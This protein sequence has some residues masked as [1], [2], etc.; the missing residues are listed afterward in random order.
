MNGESENPPRDD[1]DVPPEGLKDDLLHGA[2]E[3]AEFMFGDA[4][5]RRRIFH[6]VA[7]TKIPV[8]RL[9]AMICA[10]RSVLVRWIA[11]QE[12]RVPPTA[13]GH[14]RRRDKPDEPTPVSACP[15]PRPRGPVPVGVAGAEVPRR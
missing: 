6:L 13:G 15:P 2:A 4:G 1:G 10:R 14:H 11:E 9:G 7:T 8:F 5:Q 12:R 3:I